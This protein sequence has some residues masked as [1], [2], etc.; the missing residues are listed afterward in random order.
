MKASSHIIDALTSDVEQPTV[1]EAEPAGLAPVANQPLAEHATDDE[2]LIQ[3]MAEMRD[4]TL[5]TEDVIGL[6]AF[7]KMVLSF[8][9]NPDV[10]HVTWQRRK[11]I[12]LAA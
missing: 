3:V 9:R 8:R 6:D 10:V 4:V 5:I 11:G 7:V 1:V 2:P 12:E